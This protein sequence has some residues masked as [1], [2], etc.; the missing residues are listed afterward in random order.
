MGSACRCTTFQVPPSGRKIIVTRKSH[1]VIS[2]AAPTFALV[3][4]IHKMQASSGVTYF[5]TV[6]K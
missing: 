4:S 2:S 5:A 3:R 6:S 1:G